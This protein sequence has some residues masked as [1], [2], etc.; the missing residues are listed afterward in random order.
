MRSASAKKNLSAQGAAP[1][2]QPRI[3]GPNRHERRHTRPESQEIER[4]LETGCRSLKNGVPASPGAAKSPTPDPRLTKRAQY[5]AVYQGGKS[6]ANNL[7]ILKA[8]P[9]NL[10][11]N[12]FGLSVS[13]RVGKAVVRNHL[14]RQLKEVLRQLTFQQG[15]D[16]VYIARPPASSADY[17]QLKEAVEG[18][19][20]R[21]RLLR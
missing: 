19:A 2:S 8:M 7:L 3:S 6:W 9:N 10:T 4:P 14:K 12:R 15:W 13:K 5:E 18:M 16:I 20:R 21:A 1:A 17:S 11:F